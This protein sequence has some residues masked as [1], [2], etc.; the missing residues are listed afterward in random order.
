MAAWSLGAPE[1]KAAILPKFRPNLPEMCKHIYAT[2]FAFAAF[3]TGGSMLTWGEPLP[4]GDC[5]QVQAP[6]T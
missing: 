1:I 5:T 3:K 2:E 6:L 4:G